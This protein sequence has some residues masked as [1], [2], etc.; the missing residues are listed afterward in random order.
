MTWAG[1]ATLSGSQDLTLNGLTQLSGNQTLTV[2]NTATTT[3][4]QGIAEN[5]A[6]SKLTKNGPGTLVLAGDNSFTGGLTV[7]GGTLILDSNQHYG[8]T[9]TVNLG[10]HLV[11]QGNLLGGGN[12]SVLGG[13]VLQG[14]GTIAGMT[15]IGAGG[16]ISPGFGPG[17]FAFSNGLALRNGSQFVWELAALS[18]ANPGID[19]DQMTLTGGNLSILSGAVLDLTFI[20][21]ATAPDVSAPFWASGHRWDNIL[22]LTGTA[23]NP[24]E[25]V[26]L[27]INNASWAQLGM[28]DT[29][30]AQ[31]GLGI[32]LVWNPVAVP[33]PTSWVLLFIGATGVWIVRR[34]AHASSEV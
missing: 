27:Q 2:T 6:G 3:I 5:A 20:G 19:W 28:F 31:T 18:T 17:A 4:S 22:D 23:T 33:E 16:T 9:T 24:T 13:A 11:V 7:Q 29:V 10:T 14:E 21:S 15:T 25:F 34:W 30:A 8:G 1:N 26:N 32:D 12:V